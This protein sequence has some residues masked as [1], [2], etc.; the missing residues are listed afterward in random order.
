MKDEWTRYGNSDLTTCSD[1]LFDAEGNI[2]DFPEQF[3]HLELECQV[4]LIVV[5]FRYFPVIVFVINDLQLRLFFDVALL[6]FN[7][8][9]KFALTR[10][11]QKNL[12]LFKVDFVFVQ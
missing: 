7:F 8:Q 1:R 9:L 5:K 6:N 10:E 4:D 2:L 12:F 3:Y 11:L